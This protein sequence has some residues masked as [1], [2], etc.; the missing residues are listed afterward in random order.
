MNINQ[1]R[2]ELR[3]GRKSRGL[4]AFILAACAM[5]ALQC[6]LLMNPFSSGKKKDDSGTFLAGVGAGMSGP[7]RQAQPASPNSASALVT[8]EHGGTVTLGDEVSLYVPPGSVE[9]D[10]EIGIEKTSH[11]PSGELDGISAS[12][13][14]YRFTPAGQKFALNMPAKLSM[15]I[16]S[17]DL[18]SKGLDSRTVQLYYFDEE[19]GRYVNV[20][21]RFDQST[22]RLHAEIEHFTFYLSSALML[23]PGNNAPYVASQDTIPPTIRANA[24]IYFRATAQDFDTDGSLAGVEV[25]YRKLNPSAGAYTC[26]AMQRETRTNTLNTYAYLAP[27]TFLTAADLGGGPD[28]EYYFR[29]TDN[30]GATNQTASTTRDVKRT[31]QPGTMSVTPGTQNMSAGSSRTYRTQALDDLNVVFDIVPETHEVSKTT[32]LDPKPIG[33]VLYNEAYALAFKALHTSTGTL[34]VGMGGETAIADINVFSGSI[35]RLVILDANSQPLSGTFSVLQASEYVFDV[36]GYDEYDNVIAVIPTWSSDATLGKPIDQ[37]GRLY[38]LDGSGFGTISVSLGTVSAVQWVQI[39]ARTW[40][41]DYTG[42]AAGAAGTNAWNPTVIARNGKRAYAWYEWNGSTHSVYAQVY[43][44]GVGWSSIQDIDYGNH[45]YYPSLATDGNEIYA[46]WHEWNGSTYQIL[47]KRWNGTAWAGLVGGS[48][49]LNINIANNAYNPILSMHNGAPCVGWQEWNGTSADNVYVKCWTG[50]VWAQLGGT[51]NLDS[52]KYAFVTSMASHGGTLYATRYEWDGTAYQTY[53]ASWNGSAWV[54][55]GGSLNVTASQDSN[56]STLAIDA[57]G[58]MYVAFFESDGT[59]AY[60]VYVK[61]WDGSAWVQL[62]GAL[63]ISTADNAYYP[64]I[65]LDAAGTPYVIWQELNGSVWRV[66]VKHWNGTSWVQDGDV[67]NLNVGQSV[68]WPRIAID[69]FK[70]F[71]VWTEYDGVSTYH[72]RGKEYR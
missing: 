9:A 10:V 24:P 5:G 28:I 7:V 63:N 20:A 43:T 29:A 44:P 41:H 15:R 61:T 16:N 37:N 70:I 3:A 59:T 57:T 14:G 17:G 60:Q 11:A 34:T 12:G 35:D 40:V 62:G 33:E 53:V 54:Q 45:A 47:V 64:V 50:G 19:M 52:T 55:I 58:K 23:V 1:S 6:G 42:N 31:Y 68:S 38:T 72:I 51:L 65:A 69:E 25:C 30:L 22:G 56:R 66:F 39:T 21:G 67:L 36:V 71:A 8:V 49:S 4:F 48:D 46:A 26:S 2:R 18:Q 32:G 13:Q 27:S